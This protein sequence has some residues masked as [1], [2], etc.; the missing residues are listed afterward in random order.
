MLHDIDDFRF[1]KKN[2]LLTHNIP[3]G[4]YFFFLYYDNFCVPQLK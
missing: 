3:I 2:I 4:T 1:I